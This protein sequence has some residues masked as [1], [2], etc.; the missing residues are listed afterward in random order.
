FFPV[1]LK[2]ICVKPVKLN[3]IFA[4]PFVSNLSGHKDGVIKMDLH[5]VRIS[6]LVSCAM[7]G[8]LRLWDLKTGQTISSHSFQCQLKGLSFSPCGTKLI[9][10]G[11]DCKLNIFSISDG[12][13]VK[14][15]LT[16]HRL[17]ESPLHSIDYSKNN[18]IFGAGGDSITIW[19][20]HKKNPIKTYEL[21]TEIVTC[22][23]FNKIEENIFSICTSDKGFSVYDVRQNVKCSKLTMHMRGNSLSWHPLEANNIIVGSEDSNCYLFDI[24]NLKNPK[25]CFG[26]HA[27]S[28][29]DVD[30]SPTGQE[31]ASA[32]YDRSIRLY[33][34]DGKK[35]REVYYTD[36]MQRVFCVKYTADSQYVACG[37]D[38]M[39]IRLWKTNSSKP[40]GYLR[41]RQKSAMN[42]NSKL[43][44]RYQFH[45]EIRKINNHR[46]LPRHIYTLVEK[47]KIEREA[48][49]R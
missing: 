18:S 8:E 9:S 42:Y 31:F 40:L 14:F 33:P 32:S 38:E 26:D 20:L 29:L 37:S 16:D 48:L 12:L 41:P 10:S 44:E 39:N 11:S 4:K 27:N 1:T 43:I 5:P 46:H 6:W 3:R 23:K 15:E 21:S 36:R 22:L 24:R 45:P 25:K 13:D 30:F 2:S 7:D 34:I 49:K 35:S 17:A 19:S 28:I 47:K